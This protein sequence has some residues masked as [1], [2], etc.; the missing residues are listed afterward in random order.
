MVTF[1]KWMQQVDELGQQ[2]RFFDAPDVQFLCP[3]AQV[4][5]PYT[6]EDGFFFEAYQSGMSPRQALGEA[7][8]V[9]AW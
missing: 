7:L 6:G 4:R 8:V 5:R 3:G 9:E 1:A 2:E